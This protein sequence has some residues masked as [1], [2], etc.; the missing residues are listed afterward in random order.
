MFAHQSPNRKKKPK[1]LKRVEKHKK[2]KINCVFRAR[3]TIENV[4]IPRNY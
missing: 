4:F 3:K 1:E 2:K